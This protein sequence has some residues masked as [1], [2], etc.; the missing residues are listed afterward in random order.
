MA[1][2][3]LEEVLS[4]SAAITQRER[5]VGNHVVDQASAVLSGTATSPQRRCEARMD[6]RRMCSYEVVEASGGRS[7][8]TGQGVAL[9]VNR[10]TD[11]I[12]LHTALVPHA[13]QLIEVHTPRFGWGRTV[14][15]FEVRWA[16]PVQAES[17]GNL[18]LIGCRRI[19]GPCHYLSF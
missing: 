7:V 9:A 11:G 8:V 18:Y 12:L 2:H 3:I 17:L 4:H 16:R 19:L 1:T 5:N 6:Y 13:K 14:N 15:V 10:S